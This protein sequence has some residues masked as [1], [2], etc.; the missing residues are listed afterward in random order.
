MKNVIIN[1]PE[2]APGILKR[3]DLFAI[4]IG[5]VVGSGMVTLIGPAMAYTGYAVAAVAVMV[6]FIL[7]GVYLSKRGGIHVE[8]SVWA[9][10]RKSVV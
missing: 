7:L 3:V 8:T 6:C 5:M 10:D 9:R 1:K 4:A 2:P